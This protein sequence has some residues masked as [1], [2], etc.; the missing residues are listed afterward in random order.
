M[1]SDPGARK[2]GISDTRGGATLEI[3]R[4]AALR[5]IG[6][7]VGGMSVGLLASCADDPVETAGGEAGAGG[8]AE[9]NDVVVTPGDENTWA[10]GGTAAMTAQASYPDPFAN[11]GAACALTCVL[12]QGPCW[13]P[14]APVR[15]DVSE[16]EPGV[17]LRLVL[18]IVEADGCSA[19]PGAEVE[20]WYCN[21]DG[22]YSAD[23]AQ[24]AAFC[25]SNDEHALS[26]YFF[27][28]RAIADADG[29]VTFDGCFPG[30]YPGRSIHIHVLVRPAANAG[31][32]N[33]TNAVAVSQLFF[34][35]DVTQQIFASVNGYVAQGQPDTS[36]ESDG[37]LGA[38]QDITPYVVDYERMA[39]GAMLAWKTIAISSTDSCG[40]A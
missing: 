2:R 14:T 24:S 20:I 8:S 11:A 21:I 19:A 25:T 38:V 30:W 7:G 5:G 16:G 23:D 4:R 33:T 39:D 36:F 26:S 40:G 18:R 37:V 1:S 10:T 13:A 29:K 17:P 9:G 34:P 28:G 12:T 6:L 15:R 3:S 32:T 22:F 27:R 35:E 31:D